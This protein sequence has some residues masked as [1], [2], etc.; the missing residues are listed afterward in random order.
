MLL[1][2]SPRQEVWHGARTVRLTV[3]TMQ[4]GSGRK[5]GLQASDLHSGVTIESQGFSEVAMCL[6]AVLT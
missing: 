6:D 4:G 2:G 3:S 5:F 1:W